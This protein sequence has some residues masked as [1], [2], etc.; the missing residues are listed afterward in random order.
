MIISI[1]YNFCSHIILSPK[2][3][4]AMSLPSIVF[5]L[6][7]NFEPIIWLHLIAPFYPL[8]FLIYFTAHHW[9][10]PH[11]ISVSPLALP[12]ISPSP[13]LHPVCFALI[14]ASSFPFTSHLLRNTV[15]DLTSTQLYQVPFWAPLSAFP[16]PS[17]GMNTVLQWMDCIAQKV[18]NHIC[19]AMLLSSWD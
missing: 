13:T 8:S 11:W 7:I 17:L 3:N 10:S 14:S 18:R 12:G 15:S 16:F 5:V 1:L 19:S 6:R 9:R 4:S 2:P